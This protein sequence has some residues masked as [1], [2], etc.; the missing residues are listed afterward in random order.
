[1]TAAAADPAWAEVRTKQLFLAGR[2][3][4]GPLARS[5]GLAAWWVTSDGRVEMTPGAR[6]Q[7]VWLR[8]E[9]MLA[10]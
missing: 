9:G 5:L 2:R 3:S 8:G 6:T 10:R 7:T 4:I 1:M